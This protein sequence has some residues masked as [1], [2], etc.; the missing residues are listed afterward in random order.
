MT[1][2]V[3]REKGP[4]PWKERFAFEATKHTQHPFPPTR[5]GAPIKPIRRKR[6]GIRDLEKH[7]AKVGRL[8]WK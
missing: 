1:E 3:R 6:I 2:R 7:R 4:D 8:I 5:K